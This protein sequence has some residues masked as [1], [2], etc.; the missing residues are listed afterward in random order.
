MPRRL[1]LPLFLVFAT[2]LLGTLGFYLLWKDQG[3]TW[4]DALYMTFITITTIGY[5]EVYPLDSTG[6]ILAMLVA[7]V[8]VGSLFYLFSVIMDTVVSLRLEGTWRQREMNRISNHV[9][10][11]GLGRVGRQAALELKASGIP[12][13]ALDPSENAHQFAQENHILLFNKDG[14]EDQSLIEA[15]ILRAKGLIA[16]T[17]NDATNLLVVLSAR[18]LKPD[19]FIVARASDESAIPKLLK[20][21]ANRAISPYAIGGRRLAHLILS[22]RVVDFFETVL[23]GKESFSLEEI[24]IQKGS[25]LDGLAL[26][27]LQARGCQA[28]VLAVFRGAEPLPRPPLDF[29]LL[30]HDRILALGTTQQL[31][32]LEK[33]A[34]AVSSEP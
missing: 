10:V 15:G 1:L 12:V 23:T 27:E 13:V 6:R 24:L 5:E 33:L 32:Q 34:S 21:G 14:T 29:R 7:S 30:A 2:V 22:P 26:G 28:S 11:V 8:G 19:L 4:L 18:T 25:P 20:A 3:A 9:I 16:T 17:S 31:E